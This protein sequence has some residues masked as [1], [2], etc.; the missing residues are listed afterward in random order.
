METRYA[1]F[2][3]LKSTGIVRYRHIE[4]G[5]TGDVSRLSPDVA[6]HVKTL[7]AM[8]FLRDNL[9]IRDMTFAVL[10]AND[11]ENLASL[12][13]SIGEF[14]AFVQYLCSSP[15]ETFGDPFLHAEH[16][17]LF[18]FEPKRVPEQLVRSGSHVEPDTP[19][20]TDYERPDA[21]HEIGGYE[22]RLDGRAPLWVAKGSRIYPLTPHMWLNISQDLHIDVEHRLQSSRHLVLLAFL[23]DPR[24]EAHLCSRVLRSLR[25]YNRS[26]AID[27]AEDVALLSLAI[28]FEALLGLPREGPVTKQFKDAVALLVGPIPRLE[29]FLSQFYDARSEIAHEGETENTMFRATDSLKQADRRTAAR[30]RS[31]ASYARFIFQVCLLTIVS[32]GQMASRLGLSRMMVSNQERFEEICKTLSSTEKPSGRRL[33]LLADLIQEVDHYRFVP[34]ER[35]RLDTIVS[36]CRLACSDYSVVATDVPTEVGEGIREF[37]G[38]KFD[39]DEFRA[40]ELLQFL[41]DALKKLPRQ[42]DSAFDDPH[43]LLMALLDSAWGYAFPRYYQLERARRDSKASPSAD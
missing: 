8:F 30:Y 27:V 36:A 3:Y 41:S 39:A 13:E 10:Q 12:N 7:A 37:C 14:Q 20:Q 11:P 18:V 33:Q 9:R 25:W 38:T 16:G 15:H 28:A 5:T 2:P 6:D 23:E 34:E 40:L 22:G 43:R 19:E 21:R 26:T 32:G 35:L 29:S 24:R 4:F 1:F 42:S 17:S 31:L